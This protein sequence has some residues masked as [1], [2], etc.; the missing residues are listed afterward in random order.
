MED[1]R[2]Y[3]ENDELAV[4]PNELSIA[5]NLS[6]AEFR[7]AIKEGRLVPEQIY[8]AKARYDKFVS[9]IIA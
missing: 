2:N 3:Q 7:N 5:E 4:E 8:E 6:E 1:N 9:P